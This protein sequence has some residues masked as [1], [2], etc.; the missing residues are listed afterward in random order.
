MA[1]PRHIWISLTHSFFLQFF[2]ICPDL[3]AKKHHRPS[4]G[5]KAEGSLFA[6]DR[7]GKWICH[8]NPP[9]KEVTQVSWLLF[10]YFTLL[11][12]GFDSYFFERESLQLIHSVIHLWMCTEHLPATVPGTGLLR[13]VKTRLS[14]FVNNFFHYLALQETLKSLPGEAL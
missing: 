7:L 8:T 14:N 3:Q 9:W 5:T 6:T 13:T 1:D 4:C 2:L 11:R 10:I 12:F